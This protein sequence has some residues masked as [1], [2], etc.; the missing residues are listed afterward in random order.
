MFYEIESSAKR[1]LN[2]NV[3]TVLNRL[4]QLTKAHESSKKLIK[5]HE[6][7]LAHLSYG[8][9]EEIRICTTGT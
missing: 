5:S 7:L 3:L 6:H 9:K 1:K 4:W 8:L 2:Y